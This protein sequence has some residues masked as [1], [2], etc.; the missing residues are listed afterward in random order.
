MEAMGHDDEEPTIYPR[1]LLIRPGPTDLA[2]LNLAHAA[3]AESPPNAQ[4][5]LQP[6]PEKDQNEPG[7]APPSITPTHV[8]AAHF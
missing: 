4:L 2:F 3:L 5:D 7:L 1:M 8:D 6:P